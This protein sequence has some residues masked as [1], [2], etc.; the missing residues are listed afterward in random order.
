MARSLRSGISSP[1]VSA[2]QRGMSA[3]APLER[4]SRHTQPIENPKRF[5]ARKR[6]EEEIGRE[7]ASRLI[8]ALTSRS[9]EP[10]VP[11]PRLRLVRS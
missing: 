7:L 4:T 3:A 6:L 5:S 1:A 2:D 10:D 8:A 9:P 11:Q